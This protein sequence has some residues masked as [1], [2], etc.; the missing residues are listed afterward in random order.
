M[1]TYPGSYLPIVLTPP[2]R[3]DPP[4]NNWPPVC[5]INC[6]TVRLPVCQPARLPVRLSARPRAMPASGVFPRALAFARASSRRRSNPLRGIASPSAT[7][8]RRS[9]STV[10]LGSDE[11]PA[12][13]A[14]A[15]A[16]SQRRPLSRVPMHILVRHCRQKGR[17]PSGS[18]GSRVPCLV[19]SSHRGNHAPP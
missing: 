11:T 5:L 14:S 13:A 18:E 10:R 19:L 16:V 7:P 4:L 8:R 17:L 9:A 2:S 3:S 12:A 6:P 1:S 15:L